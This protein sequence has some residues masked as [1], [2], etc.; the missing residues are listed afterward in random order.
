M[1][2]AKMLA[3]VVKM[4]MTATTMK[5]AMTTGETRTDIDWLVAYER[6]LS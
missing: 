4:T 2:P 1:L 6:Q 5:T 3:A